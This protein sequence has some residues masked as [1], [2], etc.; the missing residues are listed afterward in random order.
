MSERKRAVNNF[1]DKDNML[2]AK[3]LHRTR[4]LYRL[5]LDAHLEALAIKQARALRKQKRRF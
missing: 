4:Q 1:E 2:S 5:G 3:K